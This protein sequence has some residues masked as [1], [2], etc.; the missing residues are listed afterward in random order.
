MERRASSQQSAQNLPAEWSPRDGDDNE[1]ADMLSRLVS[2]VGRCAFGPVV[3]EVWVMDDD[4]LKLRPYPGGFWIDPSFRTTEA[5]RNN[6]ALD[7]LIDDRLDGFI[8]PSPTGP[9]IGL[10]GCLWYEAA[11][12]SHS[13]APVGA[14]LRSLHRGSGRGATPDAAVG[15]SD[16][17][18]PVE[19]SFRNEVAPAR[20]V[21]N[22]SAR[23][24]SR[25]RRVA[26]REVGPLAADPDRPYAPRLK[27]LAEAGLGMAAGVRFEVGGVG[28]IALYLAR[29]GADRR[30]LQSAA[31]E[32]CLASATDV[33]GA[34]CA[35]RAPRL[36]SVEMRKKERADTW[37]RARRNIR[38]TVALT[39]GLLPCK[40][41]QTP[42]GA[43]EAETEAAPGKT[44]R[45]LLKEKLLRYARKNV[46]GDNQPPPPFST[47]E[48]LFTFAACFLSLLVVMGIDASL[49]PMGGLILG[50]FGALVT[51]Q[52]GLTA[53]PA[54]Q[55][56][57]VILGQALSLCI[58]LGISA[59]PDLPLWFRRTLGTSLAV[60]VMV[61]LGITHPPAGAAAMIV[62]GGMFSW[63]DVGLMLMGNAVAVVASVL[64]NN[65]NRKRQYPTFW[66]FGNWL[67]MFRG[68]GA[69]CNPP[70]KE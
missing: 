55:P 11:D 5:Q 6:E 32:A 12:P 69:S 38:V 30:K 19:A 41:A 17:D 16:A 25:R 60:S 21:R 64:I 43:E 22:L 28:G 68:D 56:R 3:C 67:N 51:L 61:R 8:P 29:T 57:N 37:R 2:D 20:S 52:Y 47:N 53:A 27:L 70:K 9:G 62:S 40:F 63:V 66:G 1:H 50:P 59:V 26:W 39:G 65:V 24:P 36:E 45:T 46:G 7:R 14:S 13:S 35:F 34:L 54:S 10:S 4:T 18:A 48:A 15:G 42:E 23:H 33:I 49:Q 58:A 44:V 31:N